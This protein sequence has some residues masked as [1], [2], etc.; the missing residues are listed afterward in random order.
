[1]KRQAPEFF[2][3]LEPGLGD[4]PPEAL[5]VAKQACQPLAQG[6]KAGPGQGGQVNYP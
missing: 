4:F 2:G 1:M 5:V 3:H 6:H